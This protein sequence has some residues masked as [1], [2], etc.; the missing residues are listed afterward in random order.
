LEL[1]WRE[2]MTLE[3][4]ELGDKRKK[5]FSANGGVGE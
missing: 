4:E 5:K 2:M 1:Q 3:N